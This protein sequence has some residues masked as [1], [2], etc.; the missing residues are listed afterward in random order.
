M[1][2]LLS[3]R[4]MLLVALTGAS[5]GAQSPAQTN[6]STTTPPPVVDTRAMIVDGKNILVKSASV[7]PDAPE[8]TGHQ[9][10]LKFLA[11]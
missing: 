5:A 9:Y 11:K 1:K 3:L 4:A 7:E 8:M 10:L 2:C 6:H